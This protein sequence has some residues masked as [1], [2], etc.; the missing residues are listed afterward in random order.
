[1]TEVNIEL[2][3]QTG[4]DRMAGRYS[5]R[6]TEQQLSDYRNNDDIAGLSLARQPMISYREGGIARLE[7]SNRFEFNRLTPIDGVLLRENKKL[8]LLGE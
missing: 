8:L 1:M 6:I 7:N 4:A 2:I 3:T 5:S